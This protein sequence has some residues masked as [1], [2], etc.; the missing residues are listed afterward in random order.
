[1]IIYYKITWKKSAVNDLKRIDKQYISGIIAEIKR[2]IENP[3]PANYKKLVDSERS[4]RIRVGNYR[5]IYQ[6]N[7]KEQIITIYHVRHRKEAYKT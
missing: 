6:V 3:F 4:Y 7:T 2:L 5:V 1:M